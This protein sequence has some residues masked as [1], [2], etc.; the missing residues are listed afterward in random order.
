MT[1]MSNSA[2]NSI[3]KKIGGRC[4][5]SAAAAVIP[6]FLIVHIK[7]KMPNFNS[8]SDFGLVTADFI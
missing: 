1:K 2:R 6:Q 3:N 7:V 8:L 4:W 5:V